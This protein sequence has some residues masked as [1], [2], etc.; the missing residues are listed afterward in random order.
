VKIE[1]II[2]RSLKPGLNQVKIGRFGPILGMKAENEVKGLTMSDQA[3]KIGNLSAG[4]LKK[5]QEIA[6]EEA[7]FLEAL[8]NLT[9]ADR[10]IFG[11]TLF[12]EYQRQR[13]IAAS[14]PSRLAPTC[15]ALNLPAP[16]DA[17]Q[18]IFAALAHE[19]TVVVDW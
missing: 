14:M 15:R 6:R 17:M 13:D 18:R 19:M 3:T 12:E 4:A 1:E 11:I 2:T 8:G 9:A 7:A 16:S 5:R 10:E